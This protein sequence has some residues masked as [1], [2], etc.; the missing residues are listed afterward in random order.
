MSAFLA[1]RYNRPESSIMLTANHSTCM[2]F[3][4]SFEPTYLLTISAIS[5]QIKPTMNR[6]NTALIQRF[7]AEEL[8]VPSERGI[9]KF[10]AIPEENL[11]NC[12]ITLAAEIDQDTKASIIIPSSTSSLSETFSLSRRLNSSKKNRISTRISQTKPSNLPTPPGTPPHGAGLALLTIQSVHNRSTSDT[13][14]FSNP[15]MD[16]LL[17]SQSNTGY[18]NDTQKTLKSLGGKKSRFFRKLIA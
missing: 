16:R 18:N 8:M 15:D 13:T 7:L 1:A 5:E 6:R 4:G 3:G 2:L 17:L 9:I 12:G 11:A 10:Q 14:T